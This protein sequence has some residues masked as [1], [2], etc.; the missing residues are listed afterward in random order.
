MWYSMI[1]FAI[2][3]ELANTRDIRFLY[4]Q[5]HAIN[6]PMALVMDLP[7]VMLALKYFC[8]GEFHL[9]MELNRRIGDCPFE[10]RPL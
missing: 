7:Q 4:L 5:T 3:Q 1:I 6:A 2:H 8:S 10:R 9:L